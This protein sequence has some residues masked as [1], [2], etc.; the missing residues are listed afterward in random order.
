M[1]QDKQHPHPIKALEIDKITSNLRDWNS[2][3]R[4]HPPPACTPESA[5]SKAGLS[6]AGPAWLG[7]GS[8]GPKPQPSPYNLISPPKGSTLSHPHP[9]PLAS[10]TNANLA[11]FV[12]MIVNE[13][14]HLGWPLTK[15]FCIVGK[16]FLCLRSVLVIFSSLCFH[17]L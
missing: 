10:L 8:V 2:S 4:N 17:W 7:S 15:Q 13:V 14:S 3:F 12:L 1:G 5:G 11:A 6:T 9:Q 16:S